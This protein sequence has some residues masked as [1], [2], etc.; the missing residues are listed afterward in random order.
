MKIHVLN[1]PGLLRPG[2]QS[3]RYP[4]HNED[5]GVEQD[6]LAFLE[7]NPALTATSPEEA[8]WHYLPVYWT[9]WHLNHN[10]GAEGLE[11]LQSLVDGVV[12]DD[13]RT[14]TVCQYDD[15]P[16]VRLGG[17]VRFL[18]SRKGDEGIDIPLLSA[19]HRKPWFPRRKKYLASFTGRIGTHGIR[20][21]MAE[22]L[23]GR[24]DVFIH[25][26]DKGARF[27]VDTMLASRIALCPRGYGG[28]SFR[29]FEAMQLGTVPLLL[30]DLDTRPFRKF[31]PW[32]DFSFYAPDASAA[33]L[34]LDDRDRRDL[35]EMGLLACRTYRQ[36]LDFGQW[37][38][39]VI[40]E[41]ED[42]S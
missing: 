32:D 21:S 17:A 34:I 15:G 5:Y 8:D 38:K 7:R 41:L 6:F 2:N 42:L 24:C 36:E 33:A 28:S 22:E 12:L 30:G 31:L 39:Y 3:F 25:D 40:K 16:V 11:E 27:F 26:G 18:A 13:A 29:L 4:S 35:L 14:F 20:R 1:T 10:Y 23:E 19:P 37:C 9:R